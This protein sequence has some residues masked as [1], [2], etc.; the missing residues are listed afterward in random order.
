MGSSKTTTTLTDWCECSLSLSRTIDRS[1]GEL[2]LLTFVVVAVGTGRSGGGGPRLLPLVAATPIVQMAVAS[3]SRSSRYDCEIFVLHGALHYYG[4]Q[5]TCGFLFFC[6]F[7]VMSVSP[8]VILL[9]LFVRVLDTSGV[10]RVNRAPAARCPSVS[11]YTV[12]PTTRFC[13]RPSYV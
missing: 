5:I 4:L 13:D 2:A 7:V 8:F 1:K 11:R 10:P 3:I 6:S 12:C 9:V